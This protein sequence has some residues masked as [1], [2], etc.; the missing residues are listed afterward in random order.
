[1]RREGRAVQGEAG[2]DPLAG[3]EALVGAEAA[4]LGDDGLEGLDLPLGAGCYEAQP[5]R[6]TLR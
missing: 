3:L 4:D 5:S 1:M 6:A 2:R